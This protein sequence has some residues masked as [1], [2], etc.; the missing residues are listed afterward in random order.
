VDAISLAEREQRSGG[1]VFDRT[2]DHID[3]G[4]SQNECRFGEEVAKEGLILVAQLWLVF[5]LDEKLRPETPV[6]EAGL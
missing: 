5:K 1:V 6:I 4:L 2:P 3:E